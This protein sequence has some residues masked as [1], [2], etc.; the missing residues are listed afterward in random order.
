ML[1]KRSLEVLKQGIEEELFSGAAYALVS[2]K[3]PGGTGTI[4]RVS[5]EYDSERVQRDTLFDVASLTKPLA[6]S[7]AILQLLDRDALSLAHSAQALLNAVSDQLTG[8]NLFH[9][10]THT[11]GLPA[12]PTGS[13]SP[14]DASLASKSEAEPGS[15]YLYS[16]TG[17]ILL[18]EIV[19]RVGGKPLDVW[20]KDEIAKPLYLENS[21]FVPDQELVIAETMAD[22]DPGIVHDPRAR[23]I[24]G[25]AGHAGLFA[26]IQ[27]IA[28]FARAL[29]GSGKALLSAGTFGSL[30]RNALNPAIGFQTLGWFCTGN[31]LMP[32]IDEFSSDSIGHSG[33]TG[34]FFL[35]DRSNQ[36]AVC[37][38]TNRVLNA[39]DDSSK[40]LELRRNWLTAAAIDC[41]LA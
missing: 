28:A 17:Y 11:S 8:I 41:G 13:G 15:A 26:S 30:F 36:C 24:G 29:L 25:V 9:L 23:Q 5:F 1:A 31:K 10:L 39:E 7:L 32:Q 22:E 38:L 21:G 16:D 6:T 27:D 14:L 2:K 34:C 20:F 35:V 37:L 4:G 12:I 19:R 3:I 18:G 40:F 33:F